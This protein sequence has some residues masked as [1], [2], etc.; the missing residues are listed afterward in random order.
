MAQT[1]K[2]HHNNVPRGELALVHDLIRVNRCSIERPPANLEVEPCPIR[3]LCVFAK[4]DCTYK[5][6]SGCR[7]A[8]S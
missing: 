6:Y 3:Q 5:D 2:R 8:K 7:V 4:G 1:K